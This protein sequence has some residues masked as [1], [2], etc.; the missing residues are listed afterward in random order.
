MKEL[1]MYSLF[2]GD[3]KGPSKITLVK[4]LMRSFVIKNRKKS[5]TIY[6]ERI[7]KKKTLKECSKI[8]GSFYLQKLTIN[9]YWEN[10]LHK[11]VK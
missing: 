8:V 11:I 7:Q 5:G 6:S 2:D 4:L 1:R 10:S 3:T 9:G